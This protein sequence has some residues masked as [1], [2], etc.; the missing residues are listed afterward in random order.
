MSSRRLND[1]D[2]E[3]VL[4]GGITP[5]DPDLAVLSDALG[6]LRRAYVN[7]LDDAHVA[8]LAGRLAAVA[9]AAPLDGG[10]VGAS[11]AGSPR[12]RAVAAA[13]ALGALGAFAA[14]G[15]AAADEAAPGDVL[16]GVDRALESVGINDGGAHERLLEVQRLVARGEVDEALQL[17]VEAVDDM[18]SLDPAD[19]EELTGILHAAEAVLSDGS[20]QSLDKRA[21]V[22]DMLTFMAETD[23]TGKDFGQAVSAHARGIFVDDSADASSTEESAASTDD[24][25]TTGGAPGNSGSSHA[26]GN[27]AGDAAAEAGSAPSATSGSGGST[28]DGASSDASAVGGSGN[29]N[30]GGN[31]ANSNAGGNSANSNAG[32]NSA[33]SNAGG[34]AANANPNA[35]KST[36]AVSE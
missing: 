29:S 32:G 18:D 36:A 35:Q 13:I 8:A 10:P 7:E 27:A 5:A 16:Y 4:A 11:R 33:N 9:A 12:R 19:V 25:A 26:G 20:D 31:S 17:S 28:D 21:Q 1:S 22:A 23:L 30:A 34:N 14:G 3:A 15:I 6:G 2:A 24:S